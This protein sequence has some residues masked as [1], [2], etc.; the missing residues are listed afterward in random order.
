[1]IRLYSPLISEIHK[2]QKLI[3]QSYFPSRKKLIKLKCRKLQIP[4][5]IKNKIR[6]I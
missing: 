4:F 2:P 5:K 6:I 3:L 1:M